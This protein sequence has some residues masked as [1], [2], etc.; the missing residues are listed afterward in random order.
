MLQSIDEDS[1][2]IAISALQ[3][4]AFASRPLSI[5]ELAEAVIINPRD[6]LPFDVENRFEEPMEL[7]RILSGLVAIYYTGCKG[8]ESSVSALDHCNNF[9]FQFTTCQHNTARVT[10]S[11][12][13][14]KEYLSSERLPQSV[15]HFGVTAS[16]THKLLAESCIKYFACYLAEVDTSSV[17]EPSIENLPQINESFFFRSCMAISTFHRTHPLLQYACEEWVKHTKNSILDPEYIPIIQGILLSPLKTTQP[18]FWTPYYMPKD[19]KPGNYNPIM[20]QLT[21]EESPLYM[22]VAL[23]FPEVCASM[24]AVGAKSEPND[25]MTRRPKHWT[26]LDEAVYFSNE[27][28]VRLLVKAGVDANL[29]EDSIHPRNH[30]Y[31]PSTLQKA[32]MLGHK[33]II[34]LLL[35]SGARIHGPEYKPGR[36]AYECN[37]LQ[38]AAENG[39]WEIFNLLVSQG[40]NVSLEDALQAATNKQNWDAFED[41]LARGCSVNHGLKITAE[42]GDLELLEILV[43]KYKADINAQAG[44]LGTALYYAAMNN[45]TNFATA[46]I[47]MG[48]DVNKAFGYG[49]ALHQ[50][51]SNRNIELV[52]ILL[53]AGADSNAKPE[54]GAGAALHTAVDRGPLEMVKLLLESGADANAT[55]GWWGSPFQAAVRMEFRSVEESIQIMTLLLKHGGDPNVCHRD[56]TTYL[57]HAGKSPLQINFTDMLSAFNSKDSTRS[58]AFDYVELIQWLLDNGA[59]FDSARESDREFLSWIEES[60][61]TTSGLSEELRQ[62]ALTLHRSIQDRQHCTSTGS[63]HSR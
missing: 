25:D 32:V 12:F 57:G 41:I 37:P 56:E 44:P 3:W 23:D 14:I 18:A 62:M 30:L 63:G 8:Y 58:G 42:S 26:A 6:S 22:A 34:G 61:K 28:I 19:Y 33:E 24:L 55:G 49:T 50:A 52:K 38:I 59:R 53:R 10:L 36:R 21:G 46:I 20:E 5:N 7:A 2:D 47:H 17:D 27:K 15:R 1:R 13:S 39:C 43:N 35:Q 48:A 60:L 11:H 9:G 16:S 40:S 45:Q 31:R 54:E 4:L 29:R 51:V